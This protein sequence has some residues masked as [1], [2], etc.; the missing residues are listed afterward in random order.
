MSCHLHEMLEQAKDNSLLW[1]LNMLDGDIELL[2]RVTTSLSSEAV[3]FYAGEFEFFMGMKVI[4][5][6]VKLPFPVC[7]IE[8]DGNATGSK[9]ITGHL[10]SLDD[11]GCLTGLFFGR[12]PGEKWRYQC[13]WTTNNQG[14][15]FVLHHD[16]H[17]NPL[18][19]EVV[20]MH[21]YLVRVFL[22]AINCTNVE[23][24]QHLP[25][26]KLQKA[27]KKKGKL[28]L[29]SYWT[30]HVDLD[31]SMGGGQPTGGTHAS[32]RLHLRRGHPRQYAPGKYCWVRAC[33]VGSG[34]NGMVH[35]EYTVKH[36]S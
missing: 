8:F 31:R 4:D 17:D 26:E 33:A 35:K 12:L 3:C 1:P 23:R 10:L 2:Y 27:R 21:I 19:P 18:K 22:S 24:E 25:A 11:N 7:W 32:P 5:E 6:L 9:T 13:F 29:F 34:K 28:P 20:Q 15:S 14:K 30:L 36:H 16:K